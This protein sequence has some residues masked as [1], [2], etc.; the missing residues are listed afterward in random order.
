MN[1]TALYISF[2]IIFGFYILVLVF[3]GCFQ[4]SVANARRKISAS[5]ETKQAPKPVEIT[6]N[7]L[8]IRIRKANVEICDTPVEEEEPVVAPAPAP[9]EPV[10]QGRLVHAEKQTF[11][12]KY[13]KLSVVDRRYL[14][15]FATFLSSKDGCE[16]HMQTNAL[17]FRYKHGQVAKATIRRGIV[18]LGF[19]IVNP[20]LGRMV[21][22][23][24]AS[25]E[26]KMKPV[27]MRLSSEEELKIAKQT[28]ELTLQ[29][30]KGEEQYRAEKR[31]EVRR[32]AARLK[33]EE[34]A[35]AKD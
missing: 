8:T 2:G 23:E 21:R 20:E 17:N 3:L 24:R 26:L 22:E 30:L 4:V 31:K 19:A 34:A 29:Y 14:D 32:E 9:E 6:S 7:D 33:H 1:L 11:A 27:K 5:R 13:A 35:V 15:D 28:A 10:P 18:H 12:E 25:S 16:K